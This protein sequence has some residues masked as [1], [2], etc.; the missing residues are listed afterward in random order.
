VT[1]K[2]LRRAVAKSQKDVA[3]ECGVNVMTVS[4]W[5]RGVA[6]PHPRHIRALATALQSTIREVQHAI[7]TQQAQKKSDTSTT[8][9]SAGTSISPQA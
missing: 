1:L 3:Q 5:E 2:D 4:A 6:I 7:D 8:N 9:D